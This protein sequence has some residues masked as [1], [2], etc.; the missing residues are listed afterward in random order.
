MPRPDFLKMRCVNTDLPECE[1]CPRDFVVSLQSIS[2]ITKNGNDRA[3]L[4]TE[5]HSFFHPLCGGRTRSI[6]TEQLFDDVVEL[7]DGK[8]SD[9][10]D[11]LMTYYKDTL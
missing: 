1:L 5:E 4:Q 8:L 11:V 10:G 9:V 6:K 2:T 3:V 7:L